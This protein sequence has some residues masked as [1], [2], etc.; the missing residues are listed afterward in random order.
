MH[1]PGNKHIFKVLLLLCLSLAGTGCGGGGGGAAG[2]GGGGDTTIISG[3][4]MKGPIKGALVRVFQL[5]AAGVRGD[6]LGSGTSGNDGSYAVPIPTAQASGPL[7]ITV[8]GQAGAVYT[9]ESKGADVPFGTA[10]SFN[11]VVDKVMPNQK[12]IVSPLSEAAF[13]KMPQILAGKPGAVS[14]EKIASSILAANARIGSLFGI[15][16]ILADP[17]GD[18]TYRAALLII[19]QMIEDSKAV[20]QTDSSGVMFVINQA[21]ADVGQ[22]PYQIYLQTLNSAADKV[23]AANPGPIATAV[24]AIKALAANPPAELDLTDVTPP[25]TPTGL[26]ASTFAIDATTSAVVLSWSPSTDNQGVAGYEVF[27]DGVRIALVTTPGFTDT[28][29]TSSVTYTYVIVA[30]DVVGNLS[31][32]SNPLSVT[33]NQASLNVTFNGQ[34]SD[35]ILGLPK[36]D[37]FPPSAPTGLVA[38]TSA[39]SATNSSVALSWNAATDNVAVTGYEVFRNGAKIAT[40]TTPG[41][42]DPSVT[43]AVTVTYFILAFDAA[44]NRSIASNQLPVTPNQASLGVTVNGQVNPN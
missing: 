23:R 40:V 38:S 18:T 36:N 8:S 6:L 31:S 24:D 41:Y 11:A 43:S 32:A 19:D 10:E 22:A 33:P 25:S 29:V 12:I 35:D 21:F 44:G 5:S 9:S 37:I 15:T 20:G 26:S 27:R 2:G 28:P 17:A 7:L 30:F 42:L 4:A 39:I 1:I 14:A 34:L 13:Q 16:N 3:I